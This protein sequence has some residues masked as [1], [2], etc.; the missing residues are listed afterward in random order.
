[1]GRELARDAVPSQRRWKRTGTESRPVVEPRTGVSRYDHTEPPALEVRLC[2]P[3][4]RMPA[5][6]AFGATSSE[7]KLT[8]TRCRS[9]FLMFFGEVRSARSWSDGGTRPYAVEPDE[10]GGPGSR[11]ELAG[12]N[13]EG[14]A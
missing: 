14:R 7:Q 2:C 6:Y 11:M 1:R 12:S 9:H 3:S 5:Q 13:T 10:L 4:C 8:C